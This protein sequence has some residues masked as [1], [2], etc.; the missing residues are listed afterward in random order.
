VGAVGAW[1]AGSAAWLHR[2]AWPAARAHL[3]TW[4]AP[5]VLLAPLPGL[6]WLSADG[7]FLWSPVTTGLAVGLALASG[8]YG[9]PAV[10]NCW[11]AEP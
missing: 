4:A 1:A 5:A 7:L 3:V 8:E 11:C 6:G 2:R 10:G 9:R